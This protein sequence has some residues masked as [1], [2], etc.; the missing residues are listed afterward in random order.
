MDDGRTFGVKLD[1][2]Q[3]EPNWIGCGYCHALVFSTEPPHGQGQPCPLKAKGDEAYVAMLDA[4]RVSY[5]RQ[6][7][8]IESM[9]AATDSR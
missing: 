6:A 4:Q 8:A 9:G 3:R 5:L 7:P 2:P 1:L